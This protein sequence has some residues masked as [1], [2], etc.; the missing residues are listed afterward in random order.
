MKKINYL[1]LAI[2]LTSVI[3]CEGDNGNDSFVI[4]FQPDA[5]GGKDA[6]IED[7][8]FDNYRN[9]N[10][11][12]SEE[13]SAISWTDD[14]T[15][16]VVRSLIDFNFDAVPIN[17]TI[18]NAKLS[19]YAFGNDGHGVG[20]DTLSG[21]NE[22]YLQRIISDWDEDLVTWN[23]QPDV[24]DANRILIPGSN[25]GMQDYIGINVTDL[26]RDI[27]NDRENSNGLMLRLRNETGF[28]RMFFA[29]SDTEEEQKRPKLDVYY[30]IA[31]LE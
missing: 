17:A 24:S 12:T 4:S 19:L 10:W 28:R 9:R 16:F 8:P 21:S 14:G 11:G 29:T 6:F 26:V 18:D 23:T 30:S 22:C 3:A 25:S 7:Y 15:P 5:I 2:V 27:I 20:H 1:F 13:F 31:T